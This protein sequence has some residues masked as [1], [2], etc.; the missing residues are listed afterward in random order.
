MTSRY[1]ALAIDL[2]G[3]LTDDEE[4]IM[5]ATHTA[6]I[7][8][9]KEGVT[10]ILASGRTTYGI[11]GIARDLRLDEYGGYILSYNGG[12]ITS[13]NDGS[14]LARHTV[15]LRY[16]PRIYDIAER[17]GLQVL[18]YL[19][20]EIITE[21]PDAPMVLEESRIN[22]DM[23]IT[24]VTDFVSSV[25]RPPFKLVICGEQEAVR[26]AH[27]LLERELHGELSFF[28]GN[29]NK[30]EICPVNV[31]KGKSLTF[32]LSEIGVKPSQLIAVGDTLNDVPMIQMAG[33]GVAMAN[34]TEAVKRSADYVTKSN[35]EDGIGHLIRK[36][37]FEP[38]ER[39]QADL[40]ALNA[41]TKNTLMDALGIVC[42]RLE[43]GYVEATMPVDV[44][45][46]Q[47]LGILHGGASLALAETVAGYG[48]V[49][50]LGEN[51]IQVGMQVSGNHIATAHEGEILKAE[52]SIIHRGRSTH[53][54]NV[55][56][57]TSTRKRVASIRVLNSIIKRR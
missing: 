1:K 6:L 19:F 5:P 37:I 55:D 18:T 20:E 32:L 21:T 36:Y 54:W 41:L 27:I 47:P 40:D 52:A 30:I 16:I 31:D 22:G 46:R 48:S 42:T 25:T 9:Q 49:Y 35:T 53:V 12:K 33:L 29:K 10:L 23:K 11:F 50:L 38:E 34:A 43:E 4:R 2:D 15:D 13:C 7:Q 26:N 44:R 8:M 56:I 17:S 57:F 51:E 28:S 45:T 14:I 24:A 39:P 3:T